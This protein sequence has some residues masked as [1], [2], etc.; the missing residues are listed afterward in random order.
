MGGIVGGLVGGMV[1]SGTAVVSAMDSEVDGAPVVAGAVGACSADV[2]GS[3]PQPATAIGV[4]AKA[5]ANCG[6]R[7]RVTATMVAARTIIRRTPTDQ[8]AFA[9]R[10]RP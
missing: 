3:S 10:Q 8:A 6:E 2:G 5:N 4:S 1:T 9:S 7:R